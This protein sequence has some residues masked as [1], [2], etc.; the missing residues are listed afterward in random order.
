LEKYGGQ[1]LKQQQSLN[2]IESFSKTLRASWPVVL[3]SLCAG[4]AIFL[5][6]A[7]RLAS[8][9]DP[10]QVVMPL[11]ASSVAQNA[12]RLASRSAGIL[13]LL[14]VTAG[15][16]LGLALSSRLR[17]FLPGTARQQ[18][19][20]HNQLTLVALVFI[21]VHMLTLLFDPM[22]AVPWYDLFIPGIPQWVNETPLFLLGYS[23]GVMAFYLAFLLGPTFYLKRWISR[24]SWLFLHRFTISVY[25]LSVFHTLAYGTDFSLSHGLPYN[26][27]LAVQVP[28]AFLLLY[29]V[30]V[31]LQQGHVQ[32]LKASMSASRKQLLEERN[33]RT[34]G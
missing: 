10:M 14:L 32:R 15:V 19:M 23:S 6:S 28:M 8:G 24:R 4:G 25:L 33:W 11:M 22:Y 12:W 13:A 5:F 26:I 1:T 2:N 34:N 31:A 16:A 18:T 3:I 30:F 20:V 29:R 21:L 9:H 7:L 17:R 27:L